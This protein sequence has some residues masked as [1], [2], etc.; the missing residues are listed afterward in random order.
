M[1]QRSWPQKASTTERS[2]PVAIPLAL[3]ATAVANT[4]I[5][6]RAVRLPISLALTKFAATKVKVS[7]LSV[8]LRSDCI[9]V[10]L[11]PGSDEH[12]SEAAPNCHDVRDTQP[13]LSLCF[14]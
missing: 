9:F 6:F 12:S 14:T 7:R 4:P 13:S 3:A 11:G 8:D 5:P 1:T 2:A 10:C